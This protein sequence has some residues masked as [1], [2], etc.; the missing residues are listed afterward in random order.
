MISCSNA[1]NFINRNNKISKSDK[2]NY[3]ERKP[4]EDDVIFEKNVEK[5]FH[6]LKLD[7][8]ESQFKSEILSILRSESTAHDSYLY[9][10][11]NFNLEKEEQDELDVPESDRISMPPIRS[12][13]PL[14]KN[15][16]LENFECVECNYNNF[17]HD[18]KY[19]DNNYNDNFEDD[20]YFNNLGEFYE[21]K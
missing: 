21:P 5:D 19:E 3:L 17:I 11:V 4:F 8:D 9:R 6:K 2:F 12:S 20:F 14:Y 18:E 16:E 1:E 13:N 7:D 10:S 15:F